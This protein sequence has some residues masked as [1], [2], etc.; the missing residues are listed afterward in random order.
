M[1]RLLNTVILLWVMGAFLGLAWE[2]SCGNPVV[3]CYRI[4]QEILVLRG[5][6]APLAARFTALTECSIPS[7]TSSTQSMTSRG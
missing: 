6:S 5:E 2:E 3:F 1:P 4:S 7:E